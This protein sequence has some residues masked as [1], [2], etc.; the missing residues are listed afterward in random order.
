MMYIIGIAGGSVVYLEELVDYGQGRTYLSKGEAK[1]LMMLEKLH[2]R[3]APLMKLLKKT[4][5]KKKRVLD[6]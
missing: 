3:S 1:I 6:M 5:L 4:S 2:A